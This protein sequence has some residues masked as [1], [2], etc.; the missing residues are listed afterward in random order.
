MTNF[1]KG[2]TTRR[3]A[4]SAASADIVTNTTATTKGHESRPS[5]QKSRIIEIFAFLEIDQSF[6]VW[7]EDSGFGHLRIN[8]QDSYG[9]SSTHWNEAQSFRPNLNRILT[10]TGD[11]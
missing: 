2:I 6:I 8:L 4:K 10:M 5:T 1:V 11:L 9:Y 7:G 3:Q